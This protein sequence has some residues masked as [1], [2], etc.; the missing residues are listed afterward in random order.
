MVPLHRAKGRPVCE[1]EVSAAVNVGDGAMAPPPPPPPLPASESPL[2]IE[3]ARGEAAP[4]AP[5]AQDTGTTP[6]TTPG[7]SSMTDASPPAAPP[8]LDPV[9]A[10][11]CA[12]RF[13]TTTLAA[14]IL[15]PRATP[16]F[17]TTLRRRKASCRARSFFPPTTASRSRSFRRWMKRPSLRGALCRARSR[18]SGRS[19]RAPAISGFCHCSNRSVILPPASR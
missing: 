2:P 11:R 6:G 16:P 17:S 14:P 5:L 8:P 4:K 12:R 9:V 18:R 7:G 13:R 19:W 3:A 1:S 10:A 15:M